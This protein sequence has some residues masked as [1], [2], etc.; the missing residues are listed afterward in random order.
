LPS[1]LHVD[2]RAVEA[3]ERTPAGKIRPVVSL[4]N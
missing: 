1:E 3:I 4:L 2:F